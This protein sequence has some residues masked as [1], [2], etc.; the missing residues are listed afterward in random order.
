MMSKTSPPGRRTA[1]SKNNNVSDIIPAAKRNFLTATEK[2]S[3][4]SRSLKRQASPESE[5]QEAEAES[6]SSPR[7]LKK[8]P[9]ITLGTPPKKQPK[10]WKTRW[11]EKINGTLTEK[12]TRRKKNEADKLL[13]DEGVIQMLNK[14]PSVYGEL[15]RS[16]SSSSSRVQRVRSAVA[17]QQVAA[18]AGK[19]SGKRTG[20]TESRKLKTEVKGAVKVEAREAASA[21]SHHNGD[22]GGPAA[23]L[24]PKRTVRNISRDFSAQEL[25]AGNFSMTKDDDCFSSLT[26]LPSEQLELLMN[27]D[28]RYSL[29]K[30]GQPG[31]NKPSPSSS[32]SRQNKD[33]SESG[34]K[35]PT[36]PLT[37]AFK[38]SFKLPPIPVSQP[39]LVEN[40]LSELL[41]LYKSEE[42]GGEPDSPLPAQYNHIHFRLYESFAQITLTSTKNRLKG[43]LTPSIIDEL[44]N[45]LS[46]TA[47][48]K[49]L[50]GLVMT[51][52]GGT[53]CQGL[54]LHFLCQDH[55][56]RRRTHAAE[57]AAAVER[58]VLALTNFPKLLV[59]AVNGVATGLGV[60]MLPLFDIVYANDKAT[61]NTFFS[62]L[63]QIPEG[64]GS[65][66]LP[67]F[68]GGLGGALSE[69]ILTG[70]H[71]TA[72]EM[73]QAGLV[74]QTFFPGRLMEEVIP[75]VKRA[76]SQ[77]N[78]GL[79]W[80]KLLL[81]QHQ[82]SQVEQVISGETELLVQM[83]T[84]K[85]FHV[86][87]VNFISTEKCLQFQKPS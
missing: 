68:T 22:T 77:H 19:L 43:S 25:V 56:E 74:T 61:F 69:M 30:Q 38:P 28:I 10:F 85:Q 44:T 24:S 39:Q 17:K 11:Q 40:R 27:C 48:V 36:A 32:K 71:L 79:Q 63:G 7:S 14:V 21:S 4:G 55:Q 35:L 15:P 6:L 20:S 60:T 76:C 3:S 72:Q 84:S 51:G 52:V 65:V 87:L 1:E 66:T 49:R 73:A 26:E 86:N 5:S 31:L 16:S 53:F 67:Q 13:V 45:A 50:Q 59:A 42:A 29:P 8:H 62:R 70:R 9:S 2:L 80:N 81:K 46:Y 58:L 41:E 34:Q 78:S 64:A 33:K 57:M 37:G 47:A 12:G 75:R 83:W 23:V 82:K 18:K 54:D